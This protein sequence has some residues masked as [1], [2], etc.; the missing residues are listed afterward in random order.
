MAVEVDALYSRIGTRADRSSGLP[1]VRGNAG[2]LPV[3]AK[4][5]FTNRDKGMRPFA[6]GGA[7]FRKIWFDYGGRR[8]IG[9]RDDSSDLG[10][11]AVVGG[12]VSIGWWRLRFSP[13]FRYLR[14]GGDN[15]PAI[16]RN[17]AQVLLGISF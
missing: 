15:F 12:G 14:W 1:S 8:N 13:E 2:Q 10:V 11:G 9:R 17:E 4:Y 5:Y 7:A 16:N 3:L 6:S